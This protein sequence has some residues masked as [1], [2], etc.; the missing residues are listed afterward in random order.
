MLTNAVVALLKLTLDDLNL[1]VNVLKYW[2]LN[3]KSDSKKAKN[4]IYACV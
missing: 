3:I 1:C 2:I 4:N